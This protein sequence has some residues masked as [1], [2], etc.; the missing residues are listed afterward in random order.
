MVRAAHRNAGVLITSRAWNFSL[1]CSFFTL[2][3]SFFVRLIRESRDAARVSNAR[4]PFFALPC[5]RRRR[6]RRSSQDSP[7]FINK[8][9]RAPTHL[10]SLLPFTSSRPI[11][12]LCVLL[13][14]PFFSIFLYISFYFSRAAVN[15]RARF[16]ARCA[17]R[18]KTRHRNNNNNETK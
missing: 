18:Q 2:G 4:I 6:R 8:D 1:F 16:L 7:R 3:I 17:V 14:L 15:P 11:G 9:A 12:C 5:Q 10:V 13:L